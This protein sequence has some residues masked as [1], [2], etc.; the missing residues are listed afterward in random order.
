MVGD[1][2]EDFLSAKETGI[3]FISMIKKLGDDK[4]LFINQISHIF[5]RGKG[6]F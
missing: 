3:N 4:T 1:S 6:V 2:L 5:E